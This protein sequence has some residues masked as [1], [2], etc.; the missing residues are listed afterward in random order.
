MKKNINL[1]AIS[2]L[3]KVWLLTVDKKDLFE[4]IPEDPNGPAYDF[5]EFCEDFDLSEELINMVFED[6]FKQK[7]PDVKIPIEPVTPEEPVE[8]KDRFESL[9]VFSCKP[10]TRI[11]GHPKS[12]CRVSVNFNRYDF[13]IK[14]VFNNDCGEF[15]IPT[16]T[17]D[18]M[19]HG[20][21]DY[22][23]FE[24][25]KGTPV[26]FQKAMKDKRIA[27]KVEAFKVIK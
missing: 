12:A 14:F 18:Y 9:G 4:K 17:K 7:L 8:P 16:A 2:L 3:L 19:P 22:V 6:R 27:T 15:T 10:Y 23:Y 5:T 11:P 20:K 1:P 25:E 21:E 24:W 13:P 26:V